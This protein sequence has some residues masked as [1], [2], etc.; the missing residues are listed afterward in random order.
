LK[1]EDKREVVSDLQQRLLRAKVA[2]LTRFSGLNVERMTQ[3]RRDLRKA[4]VEYRIIKNTLFRLA[5]Q[6]SPQEIL[7]PH[8][9]GPLAVAWSEKDPVG[10][11]K[12][13]A[14]YSKDFARCRFW[15][16]VRRQALGRQGHS[17][18]GEPA[19]PRGTARDDS[20]MTQAPATGLVRLFNTPGTQMAQ[21]L[22]ARSEQP[23]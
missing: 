18:V 20:G 15:W 13:L 5:I 23:S 8:L 11:A 16:P 4:G 10:P 1:R 22:K 19:Q 7:S 12:I 6:G 14:K 17:G 2:I 21:V 3:L 9:E